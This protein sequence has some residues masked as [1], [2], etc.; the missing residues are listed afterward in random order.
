MR[1]NQLSFPA[2]FLWGA[3][4]AAHQTEGNNV[5]SD[6]WVREHAVGT[7][8]AEPSG[9]ACDSYHRYAEDIVLN[10]RLGFNTYRFGIEWAR[11]EP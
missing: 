1:P 11:I 8:V 10:A 7:S 2:D 6:W 9:D 3:A 5:N 4:T